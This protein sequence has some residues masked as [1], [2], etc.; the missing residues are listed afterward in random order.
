[1][2]SI[3]Y[4]TMTEAVKGLRQ[5]GF[6]VDFNL[7]ENCLVCHNNK[8]DIE[9]FE[10]VEMHRFEGDTDPADESIVYAIQSLT[11][12]KG[13]LVN[14]YGISAEAMSTEMAQKLNMHKS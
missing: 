9:D 2:S 10:I 4:D 14:G 7:L 1:M 13:I 8:F 5:R 3:T 12:V 6:T 11:G